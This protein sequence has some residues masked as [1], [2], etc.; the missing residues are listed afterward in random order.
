MR[1]LNYRKTL[2]YNLIMAEIRNADFDTPD[3]TGVVWLASM[4]QVAYVEFGETFP[5]YTP[6]AHLRM[7][8]RSTLSGF[9]ADKLIE[10]IDRDGVTFPDLM[11]AAWTVVRY[12][13]MR[14]HYLEGSR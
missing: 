1:T 9:A 10:M 13:S 8:D 2:G 7:L 14:A 11:E 3:G 4:A 6:A 5:E 12:L